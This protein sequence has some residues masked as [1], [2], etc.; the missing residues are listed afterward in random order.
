METGGT[1]DSSNSGAMTGGTM[2]SSMY[3]KGGGV[4][5]FNV[6]DIVKIKSGYS[7]YDNKNAE[8]VKIMPDNKTLELKIK[9]KVGN[10]Y[11]KFEKKEVEKYSKGGGVEQIQMELELIKKKYPK[12]N[13]SYYFAKNPNGKNY[14]VQAKENGKI[15]YSSYQK[16]ANG[17]GVGKYGIVNDLRTLNAIAKKYFLSFDKKF[18]YYT[19]NAYD[20]SK[21]ETLP[22]YFTLDNRVFELKYYS[23]SFKPFLVE[24]DP[25]DLVYRKDTNEPAFKNYPN[26]KWDTN[27]YY[28]KYAKGGGL[29][30][31]PKGNKGLPKLPESVRNKM[32]Y[33]AKGGKME[34]GGTAESSE[35]GE[36][37][38][39]ENQSS[40][41][42][43][44]GISTGFTY[45][46]G[47]L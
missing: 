23:G 16:Y 6:G 28:T 46:V 8:I 32:G 9:H 2:A 14:V 5:S 38:G 45:D 36:P 37:I 44:G 33:M 25:K 15:V 34:W 21:G 39:G 35:T 47:G 13:V 27:K 31:I 1:A 22:N 40:M 24:L 26:P 30:H 12:A 20:N 4:E 10:E 41:F 43:N 18:K 3:K 7:Q 42:E 29:K 19:G 11:V 17:G